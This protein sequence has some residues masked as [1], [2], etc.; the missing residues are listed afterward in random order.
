MTSKTKL[1]ELI[2]NLTKERT[3]VSDQIRITIISALIGNDKLRRFSVLNDNHKANTMDLM[4]FDIFN[5][6]YYKKYVNKKSPYYHA[7]DNILEHYLEYSI[8]NNNGRGINTLRDMFIGEA[9][10]EVEKSGTGFFDRLKS[11]GSGIINRN[12]PKNTS[13]PQ[14]TG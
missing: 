13:P 3:N 8:S 9:E 10:H 7:L 4:K 12:K 6:F 2:E 14:L 5:E 1:E 11:F